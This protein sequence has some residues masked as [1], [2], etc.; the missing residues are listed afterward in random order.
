MQLNEILGLRRPTVPT[1]DWVQTIKR[2]SGGGSVKGNQFHFAAP[3]NEV[4]MMM[5]RYF[6]KLDEESWSSDDGWNIRLVPG[7]ST[8]VFTSN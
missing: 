2:F 7:Q 5:D 4:V 6:E 8:L 1:A 3:R